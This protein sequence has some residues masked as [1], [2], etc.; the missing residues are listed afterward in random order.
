MAFAHICEHCI[1]DL[2]TNHSMSVTLVRKTRNIVNHIL[3]A[4]D[5]SKT[6]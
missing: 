3:T 6:I 1:C 4:R 5:V 2:A